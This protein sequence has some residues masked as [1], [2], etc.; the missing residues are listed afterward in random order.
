MIDKIL[1]HLRR[2]QGRDSNKKRHK[3]IL[4]VIHTVE[5]L[6]Q[7][8]GDQ[9]LFASLALLV[10]LN[11]QACTISAY[12]YDLLCTML[13]MGLITSINALINIADYFYRGI[14]MGVVRFCC[15]ILQLIGT[16]IVLSV[17]QTNSFPSKARTLAIMPAACFEKMSAGDYLGFS[18]FGDFITNVKLVTTNTTLTNTTLLGQVA[19]NIKSETSSIS[20]VGEYATLILFM[21]FATFILIFEFWEVK[22]RHLK[23]PAWDTVRWIGIVLTGASIIGSLVIVI[24]STVHYSTLRAGMEVAEWYRVADEDNWTFSQLL[25]V[26]LLGSGALAFAKAVEGMLL[27]PHITTQLTCA[28]CRFF[29]C[30]RTPP[31]TSN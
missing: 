2:V 20:G 24:I 15:I 18:D 26:F 23:S 12:H 21:V 13:L 6:V 27:G 9:I 28:P 19:E 10:T 7:H 3:L 1:Y 30:I 25:T 11:H 4:K 8:L 22:R 16:C 17:R 5:S 14:A 29:Q 31:S